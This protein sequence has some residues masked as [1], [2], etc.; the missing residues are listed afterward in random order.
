M[1][2]ILGLVLALGLVFGIATSDKVEVVSD[3]GGDVRPNG[4][5]TEVAGATLFSDPGGDIRP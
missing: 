4:E 3:P 2:K 1:K 5:T